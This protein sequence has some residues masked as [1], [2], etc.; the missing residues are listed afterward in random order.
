MPPVIHR[1]DRLSS[2]FPVA[3]HQRPILAFVAQSLAAGRFGEHVLVVAG[4]E[5]PGLQGFGRYARTTVDIFSAGGSAGQSG[6][7][8]R[9]PSCPPPA[10]RARR[11]RGSACPC[12]APGRLRKA[13]RRTAVAA[14]HRRCGVHS[15]H[16]CRCA[17]RQG[18]AMPRPDSW[19]G[20]PV[21]VLPPEMIV[22]STGSVRLFRKSLTGSGASRPHCFLE[23]L[24]DDNR[25]PQRFHGMCALCCLGGHRLGP[26]LIDQVELFQGRQANVV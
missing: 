17:D 15:K 2:L 26:L 23:Q 3:E 14:N 16:P 13:S 10:I 25:L 22:R 1:W 9:C 18:T 19:R 4:A 21:L 6:T 20:S 8:P 11:S 24:Q 5:E 7:V 12:Y